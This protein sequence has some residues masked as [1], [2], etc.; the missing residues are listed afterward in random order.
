MRA[1]G[2]IAFAIFFPVAAHATALININTANAVLLDT[3]PGIGPSYA[4]RIVDYRTAH[5]AFARIED[6]Q[7]VSGIGPSIFA[8]IKSLIT[9]GDAGTENVPA[10]SSTPIAASSS[11]S[12]STYV[13]PPSA[14]SLE[15]NGD[16][17][18]RLNVP[19]H[20][21]ARVTVKGGALDT[22]AQ[23]LWS[24]GDGSSSAGSV[25]EKTYRYAGTYL[26]TA[27]AIDGSARARDD[28][29]IT[30][31]PTQVRML[32]VTRDGITIAN[33]SNDRLDLSGWRLMSG[34][35]SFRFPE[36]TTILPT[37][38]VLFP[39]IITNLPFEPDVTL[40]Y[41][42]GIIAVRPGTPAEST[43]QLSESA[44]SSYKVQ[45]V[46]LDEPPARKV[47]TITKVPTNTRTHEQA[48]IAPTATVE[49][50]A[51]GAAPAVKTGKTGIF[52]SP[53]TLSLLGVIAAAGG[54]FILL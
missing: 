39:F 32:P 19:L 34:T 16:E 5:G 50:A 53:W 10:A 43:T 4:A 33:D 28:F 51:V 17:V 23:V 25:V 30:V 41:P 29:L 44:T 6:I 27:T 20:L 45:T 8:D 14:I 52:H 2:L 1:I 13:P 18:V 3:L 48:V 9:V 15:V 54:A 26:V 40:L 49:P 47:E 22:S 11:G 38:S 35:G 37:S 46:L 36:G 42:D 31:K 12:A 24:F 7:N 21:S